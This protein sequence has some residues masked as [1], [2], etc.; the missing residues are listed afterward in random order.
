MSQRKKKNKGNEAATTEKPKPKKKGQLKSY[1]EVITQ[2]AKSDDGIFTVHKIGDKYY[3]EIPQDLFGKDMLWV[4]R[5]AKIPAGLGGGFMIAGSKV[6][7]QVVQWSRVENKIFLRT[8]SYSNVADES[9]PIYESVQNNNYAPIIFAGKVEAL[10]EDSSAVVVN[11]TDLFTKDVKAIS[12]LSSGNRTRYK[13]RRLDASRSYIEGIKSYPLNIEVR[14]DMTFDSDSPPS[15]ARAGTI[16][17]LVNQSMIMLPE[18]I[19][20]PRYHDPRVG[21]FSIAQIDYTSEELKADQKRYIRRWRLEPKDPAA[22]A[23]GELV[24]PI[25]P[26][27]YYIDPATPMKWR[28]YFRQGIEDWQK[29][30]EVAGF[31]NAIIA[32]D[33]PSKEEDPEFSPE[34]I[35]Y[36]V[37]RYVA[38]T[39]RNAVG[40]SVSDPRSGEIIES[41]IIW[42]H[43]HLRSYRNRY[44]LETGAANPNARTLNTPEADIG[45]MMRMVIAHE[46][47]HA[48]GLPHNMKASA[49][50]PVDSLR[51]GSFTQRM[52]IAATIMD[53]ARYNYIAQPGD[54][55]IRFVRQL[56]PYD[57]YSINW[58][59]R[60]IPN[61]NSSEQER[62]TLNQWIKEKEGDPVYMF[63]SGRGQID[64][65]SQT[66]GIGADPV[67]ASTYGLANLKKVAPNLVEWTATD[68][69]DYTDLSELY[70]ELVGVWSRYI[71]HV[72]TNV[73]GVNE[74]LKSSDQDGVV[75]EP[76]T[77]AKQKESMNWLLANAFV[78]PQWLLDP[79][80][81]RRMEDAGALERI[82]RLQSRHL[83]NLL[84]FERLQRLSEI[85]AFSPQ[86]SYTMIEMMSDLRNGVWSELARGRTIDPY[87]RNLQR[88]YLERMQY[89]MTEEQRPIP[90]AFRAFVRRT[91]VDVS[92]SDIRPMV[93]AELKVL[94]GQIRSALARTSDR[95]SR[96]HLEDARE[97]IDSILNPN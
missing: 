30:F 19:M 57:E 41:D 76:L 29:A 16:S 44:L 34:D 93:R 69:K 54:E 91:Q 24:E 87:R 66:E 84:S 74:T 15:N 2:D 96:Y 27:V 40:P 62:A 78:T 14:Q 8:V 47:G 37:V 83:N 12:G 17:M 26:I 56:G 32:K 18:D 94:D 64:P 79:E 13:A 52:G 67:M 22:Y 92:Q 46:V 82:R 48:L 6:N 75:Y 7:E 23:R 85:A 11:V 9:A 25:K 81:L 58:G 39:T 51:S 95:T 71:G 59:Y 61:A 86:S 10:S 73:G 45:E 77:E 49:A 63:G 55:N 42:F 65:D 33:P 38:S 80:M 3:Y 88:A 43:N 60:V 72:V 28:P 53:Y 68:G 35:R 70:G 4:T 50:Y 21:W 20:Q 36:S 5:I 1:S 90:A 31:K 97:R 89:L